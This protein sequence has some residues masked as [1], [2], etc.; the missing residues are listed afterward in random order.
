M[1]AFDLSHALDTGV[2]VYPDD[3][4]VELAPHA[5]HAE[6]GYRVTGVAMGSHSGTHVDAPSHTE[7]DGRGLD[8]FPVDEFVFD[9]VRVDLTE[10]SA[11]DP[12]ESADL[13]A[14]DA[15]LLVLHTGWDAHWGTDHYLDH[16]YLTPDAARELADGGY[17]VA[18]DAL[19]VDPTPSGAAAPDEPAGFQAHHALLGDERLVVENLTGVGAPPDRFTLHAHPLPLSGADGAPVRAVAVA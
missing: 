5:T 6:D 16:P 3:P 8:E 19:N 14:P 9:A 11:R 13:P 4:P 18:V 10:L 1:P 12:I 17:H 7:P 15:D 2:Q